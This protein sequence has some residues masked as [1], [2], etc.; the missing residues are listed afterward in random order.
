[1]EKNR[2]EENDWENTHLYWRSLL[3]L[4]DILIMWLVRK[5]DLGSWSSL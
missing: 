5:P 3:P 4:V 1:M 2:G